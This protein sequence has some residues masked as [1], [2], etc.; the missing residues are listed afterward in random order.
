MLP[1]LQEFLTELVQT[2]ALVCTV[3]RD[4]AVS[5]LFLKNAPQKVEFAD[6][7]ATIE[8]E[9][10]HIHADL[11]TV[12]RV[13]FEESRGHEGSISPLISL[14]DE[15]GNAVLRFYFPHVSQTY[16]TWTAE[17]LGLFEQFRTRYEEKT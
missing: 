12:A 6:A 17:E 8:C 14:D 16:K 4:G 3:S 13:R 11:S 9:G 1:H 15:Q 2:P 10:W 7:W 5:E